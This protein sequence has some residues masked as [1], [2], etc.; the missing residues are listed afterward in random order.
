MTDLP[1]DA[2][3]LGDEALLLLEGPDSRTFLHG[4]TTAD[5]AQSAPGAAIA[6]AFC[7]LKGRVLADFLAVVVTESRIVLRM[8]AA[9]ASRLSEHLK[10]Y[11]MF[12]KSTLT[13]LPGAVLGSA[14]A[15]GTES[16][17]ADATGEHQRSIDVGTSLLTVPRWGTCAEYWQLGGPAP[18]GNTDLDR[19]HCL[20]ILAG[21]ARIESA[22]WGRYLPQ[23]LNY[24][25]RH[26]VSF[27]KGCYTGQEVIARLHFRGQPK[28]RLSV[29]Q[30]V[31][32]AST[33]PGTPVFL[34]G[35]EQAAGSI[36][37]AARDGADRQL[38]LVETT[39]SALDT[40]LFLSGSGHRLEPL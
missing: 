37:N 7:D 18:Q 29:A 19:W 13:P 25:L 22:T 8:R 21:E 27:N 20:A 24:D 34:E 35:A 23:D 9:V 16:P 26:W 33:E 6:G 5:V 40:G 4:Q 28:R 12:S 14:G 38:V 15:N 30:V 11:L 1:S 31:A 3:L 32:T 17:S 10:K 2:L 36:V 39:A